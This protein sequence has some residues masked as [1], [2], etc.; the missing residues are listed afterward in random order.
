MEWQKQSTREKSSWFDNNRSDC[1]WMDVLYRSG[2]VRNCIFFIMSYFQLTLLLSKT[3]WRS[4][5]VLFSSHSTLTYTS[6]QRYHSIH[7]IYALEILQEFSRRDAFYQRR[8]GCKLTAL[9][10]F[11]NNSFDYN[12]SPL[13]TQHGL[14]I[15]NMTRIVKPGW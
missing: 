10:W 13:S 12:H 3:N 4:Y 1:R 14:A 6:F 2:D 9:L 11:A 7:G 15:H 8:V 5:L